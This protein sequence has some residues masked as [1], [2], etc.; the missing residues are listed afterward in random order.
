MASRELQEGNKT[1]RK[2]EENEA[3][4]SYLTPGKERG[5]ER[6]WEKIHTTRQSRIIIIT[7]PRYVLTNLRVNL[8]VWCNEVLMI[9][10]FFHDD[11]VV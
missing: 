3:H 11:E 4:L 5:K 9:R 7:L 8:W 2:P 6:K 1:V 10:V